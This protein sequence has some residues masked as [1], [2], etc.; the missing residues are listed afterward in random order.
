M[1]ISLVLLFLCIITTVPTKG[2]NNKRQDDLALK[3]LIQLPPEKTANAP[4]IILLHGYG[5]NEQD[6]FDLKDNF[7]AKYIIVSA[8]APFTVSRNGYQW[9]GI[10]VVNS[11]SNVEN[12]QLASSSKLLTRFINQ[13]ANKYHADKGNIYVMGFS[14]GAMM[15][16]EIGLSNPGML[17][18]I[19]VLSGRI[20][21]SLKVKIHNIP[22]LKNLKIFISHGTA[23]DRISFKEGKESYEYLKSLGLNPEFHA[24]TG[25]GHTI[26]NQVVKDLLNWLN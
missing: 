5:S 11:S 3:Y 21:P 1:R 23:D 22:A 2:Q 18:G 6:I 15:S 16:Y 20:L 4:M 8:R 17:K 9:F 26:T 13:V 19:G 10:G 7:P 24:Y 25:M 12:E 14:Q